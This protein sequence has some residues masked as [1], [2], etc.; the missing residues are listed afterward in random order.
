MNNLYLVISNEYV[1]Y[2]AYDSAVISAKTE[3]EANS[4]FVELEKS[5]NQAY[6][7]NEVE[8]IGYATDDI[9]GIVLSSYNAG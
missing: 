9:S 6:S 2:E 5:C 8:L 7:D 3:E 1:G 4:I